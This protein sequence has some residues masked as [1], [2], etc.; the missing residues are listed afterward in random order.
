MSARSTRGGLRE[1]GTPSRRG[2]GREREGKMRASPL[3]AAAAL[4]FMLAIPMAAP[5]TTEG[6]AL[7]IGPVQAC[8]EGH[9]E[10][11]RYRD[12]L[13]TAGW[14]RAGPEIRADVTMRLADAFEPVSPSRA[15]QGR[16]DPDALRSANR[17]HWFSI[18]AERTLMV[19][20][21]A[22]LFLTGR[23]ADDG[24]RAI[25][26][27][28][29]MADPSVVDAIF[30]GALPADDDAP[31]PDEIAVIE[32]GPVALDGQGRLHVLASRLPPAAESDDALSATHGFMTR[33]I[34]P[35]SDDTATEAPD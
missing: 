9:F 24:Q 18:T 28:V 21:G 31:D 34:F 5:A 32:Y 12:A 2:P 6:L 20:P 1:D 3:P 4:A 16:G 27:W 17:A 23:S 7:P 15:D 25:E 13:E 8:L 35:P 22:V 11:E 29:A 19:R 30:D 14:E 26:C 10:P 33:A